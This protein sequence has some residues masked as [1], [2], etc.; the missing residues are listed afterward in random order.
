MS[1]LRIRPPAPGDRERCSPGCCA[2][3]RRSRRTGASRSA[4]VPSPARGLVDA[5]LPD[6]LRG[7]AVLGFVGERLVAH[8]LWVR[9]GAASA[10]EIALVVADAHQ[11]TG[12]RHRD[13]RGADG[14]PGRPWVERVEVFA[15]AT[16]EAV[17]GW[18]RGRRPTPYANGT[19]RPSPTRSRR[20]RP[21]GEPH[22]QADRDLERTASPERDV[23]RRR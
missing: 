2:G 17:T 9:V 11:G 4:S 7:A 20:G 19:A 23:G 18:S 10:A 5:L 8:G 13:R 3:C 15:S 6:G 12:N 1:R 16:N 22:R 14:R 21:R